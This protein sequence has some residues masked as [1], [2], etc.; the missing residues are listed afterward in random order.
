MR[1]SPE[2]GD[3]G[4]VLGWDYS[5]SSCIKEEPAADIHTLAR[6]PPAISGSTLRLQSQH[7]GHGRK[8]VQLFSNSAY[9]GK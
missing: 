6:V 3:L 5:M 1:L 8:Q 2:G 7:Y 4:D 9:S